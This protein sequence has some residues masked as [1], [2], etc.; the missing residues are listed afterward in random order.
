VRR[1]NRDIDGKF[2]FVLL[3]VLHAAGRTNKAI[4][5]VEQM[6]E[7]GEGYHCAIP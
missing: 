2:C 3:F 1:V 5:A 6:D 7:G 4:G